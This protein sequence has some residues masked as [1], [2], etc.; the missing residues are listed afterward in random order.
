MPEVDGFEVL[1]E[2]KG[3]KTTRSIPVVVV[4]AK[5]LSSVEQELL[6]QRAQTLLQKGLFDQQ[7][8]LADVSTALDRLSFERD[9]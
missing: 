2:L 4:T 1:E 8:L 5:E 3:N 6:K 7:Q 9:R